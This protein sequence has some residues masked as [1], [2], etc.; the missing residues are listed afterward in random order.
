VII[1]TKR[2]IL[3]TWKES[4]AEPYFKINQDPKVIEYLRGPLTMEQVQDF[5]DTVNACQNKYGYALWAARLR[6][7][8][9][10]IGYIGL[11]YVDWPAHFTP[12]TEVG[13]RLGSP[14]WGQGLATEGALA[15]LDYG[16]NQCQLTEIVS[17]TVPANQRSIRVME[18]IGLK[19]D[20]QGDF[21]HPKL[22]ANHPL[23]RHI[24]YRLKK[25]SNI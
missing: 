17:F 25:P 1:E 13:W 6:T 23:S 14:Y 19:R 5:I 12:A 3:S 7:T 24:L 8:G 22:A 21:A 15:A 9:T 2:L 10:L 4:D 20:L 16:F 18:K 11:N